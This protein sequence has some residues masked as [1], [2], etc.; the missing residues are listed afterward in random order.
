MFGARTHIALLRSE[1]VLS[2]NMSYKH[3][4]ALRLGRD[5]WFEL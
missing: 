2:G 3:L 5:L 4:A 1:R